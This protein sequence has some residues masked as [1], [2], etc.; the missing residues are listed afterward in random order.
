MLNLVVHMIRR[1]LWA[2]SLATLALPLA[3]AHADT[4]PS[5][6]IRLVVPYAS[7]GPTD[8]LARV[9]AQGMAIG[10]GRPVIVENRPGAGSII[11]VDFVA[12][13]QPDGYTLLF[14]TGAALVINPLLNTKLPYKANDFAPISTVAAYT[15]F[16]SVNPNLGFNSLADLI[17]YAK[18]N[19]GKLAFGSAGYGTSNHLA[20]ELLKKMAGIDLLHVPYKGNAAAMTD[21]IGGNI[22]MMF[23][24]P[25]TTMPYAQAGKVRLLGTTGKQPSPLAPQVPTIASGGVPGYDVTSWFGVFAPARTPPEIVTKLSSMI[26]TVLNDPA[27]AARLSGLGYQVFGST[28]DT[29]DEMMVVDTKLWTDV[30]RE[31]NIKLE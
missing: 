11:G 20:G 10:L 25:A 15:M 7:G 29:L 30:I 16:L 14:V 24:L 1:F 13:A 8:Q 17:T 12:K 31:A 19:P 3:S 23:D 26:V 28:P 9:L 21:V 4:Y 22:S 27:T 2:T 6:L 5:R 18:H